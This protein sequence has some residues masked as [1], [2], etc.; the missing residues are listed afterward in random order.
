MNFAGEFPIRLVISVV[1]IIGAYQFYFWCQRHPIFTPR[2]WHFAIDE[3]IA[4]RPGWS[5]IYSLLYYPAILLL[6]YI[7]IDAAHFVYMAFSFL[8]LL[9]AQMA[10]FMFFP[11][12][13]PAHWRAM[14]AG[15]TMSERFLL[16]VQKFDAPSNCFPSM[17]VS[18]AMLAALHAMPVL[19]Q[20]AYAFP[21]LITVSCVFTK[22][23]Y[24]IDLP[25]GA[26]LGWGIF[27]I[28][29]WMY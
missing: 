27:E 5:W 12:E 6:N 17:H 2:V 14:N 22:Q 20:W 10:F 8:L 4:Y 21:V 29:K 9:L 3:R 7:A 16:Y 25:A 28:F 15:K 24:L 19:G 1:L 18:V 13:T 23:H 26:A 11:V